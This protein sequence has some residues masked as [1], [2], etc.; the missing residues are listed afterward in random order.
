MT[1]TLSD[2]INKVRT[3]LVEQSTRFFTDEIIKDNINMVLGEVAE[4]T[5]CNVIVVKIKMKVDT[6]GINLPPD[7]I[8]PADFFVNDQK[9]KRIS[10]KDIDL[11]KGDDYRFKPD[12]VY[13]IRNHKL[14]TLGGLKL[15][16]EL[17]LYYKKYFDEL[18]NMTDELPQEFCNMNFLNMLVYGTCALLKEMD[19]DYQTA[20]YYRNIYAYKKNM[21]EKN[22]K[23]RE[24]GSMRWKTLGY[25]EN[26]LKVL[27]SGDRINRETNEY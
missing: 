3:K 8:E 9:Y 16:D 22:V 19:E 20:Q 18:V 23:R 6:D 4:D 15:N 7:I 13:Y 26:N 25:D 17:T 27:Y 12:F 10:F 14:I 5:G 21:I 24:R 1:I 11:Y 2:I